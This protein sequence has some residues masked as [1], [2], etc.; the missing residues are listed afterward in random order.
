M[1]SNGREIHWSKI[2]S[3]TQTMEENLP[4][5]SL[6]PTYKQKEYNMRL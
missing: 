4:P 1:A 3:F 5:L 6:K 2:E